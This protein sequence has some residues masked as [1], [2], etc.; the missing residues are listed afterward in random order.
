[1]K[2]KLE[3]PDLWN[4]LGMSKDNGGRWYPKDTAPEVVKEYVSQ[5]RSP[6]RSWPNSYAT[7]LLTAKFAKHLKAAAPDLAKQCGL[8]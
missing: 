8:E 7:P 1:M 2:T 6:S 3:W 4:N 5:Y